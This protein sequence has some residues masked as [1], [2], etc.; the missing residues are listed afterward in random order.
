MAADSTRTAS[1]SHKTDPRHKARV[2][3]AMLLTH[4][5]YQAL[6]IPEVGALSLPQ[7]PPEL[8]AVWRLRPDLSRAFPLTD[9]AGYVGLLDWALSIGRREDS[10]IARAVAED[11]VLASTVG[12]L[13]GGA[14]DGLSWQALL[15]WFTREGAAH[16]FDFRDTAQRSAVID[17]FV[18]SGA[19]EAGLCDRLTPTE[20]ERAGSVVL[21]EAMPIVRLFLAVY[22]ARPDLQSSFDL[23]TFEG[24]RDLV[25]WHLVNGIREYG[26][27]Q[28]LFERQNEAA[29][30]WAVTRQT[31]QPAVEPETQPAAESVVEEVPK[32]ANRR[33]RS[34]TRAVRH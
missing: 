11:E 5:E 3:F 34:E 7:L 32:P 10:V 9:L 28:V 21:G 25:I 15:C 16:E 13:A 17:W 2:A 6:A 30:A 22:R 12:G 14:D 19:V 26:Y 4:D 8:Y 18:D 20:T 27:P 24:R 33:S 31:T 23:D 1:E 29:K